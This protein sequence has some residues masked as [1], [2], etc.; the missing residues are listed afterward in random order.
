MSRVWRQ[1]MTV[2]C[3]FCQKGSARVRMNMKVLYF[4]V[5]RLFESQ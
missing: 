1:R 3:E 5:H 4:T 2:L